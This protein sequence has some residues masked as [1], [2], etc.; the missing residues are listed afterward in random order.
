[1]L[2]PVS[3]F[4][5]PYPDR[6]LR[7]QADIWLAR[8][9][10]IFSLEQRV[11]QNFRLDLGGNSGIFHLFSGFVDFLDYRFSGFFNLFFCTFGGLINLLPCLFGCPLLLA[12][13]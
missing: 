10:L 5:H 13:G 4:G 7:W 9:A 1:M 2:I 3:F 11:A 12:T 8:S 6:Y